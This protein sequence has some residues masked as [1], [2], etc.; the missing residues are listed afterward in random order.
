MTTA[1]LI[2]IWPPGNIAT[3][4]EGIRWVL[5]AHTNATN[6]KSI[7]N[8]SVSTGI[9]TTFNN[10]VNVVSNAGV[11]AVAAA[12]NLHANACRISFR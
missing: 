12:G 5:S 10:A 11:M 4:V 8:L 6:K 3:V 7:M 9:S 2:L 1:T